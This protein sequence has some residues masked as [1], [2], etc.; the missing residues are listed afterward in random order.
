MQSSSKE[1]E[2]KSSFVRYACA[3]SGHTSKECRAGKSNA[4]DE[5]SWHETW[6]EQIATDDPA[7]LT[8]V[9]LMSRGLMTFGG[10]RM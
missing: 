3:C 10:L 9:C 4:A 6:S 8:S 5:T 7:Q 1:E 2:G